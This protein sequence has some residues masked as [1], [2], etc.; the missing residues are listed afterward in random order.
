MLIL[1]IYYFDS[2]YIYMKNEII[3]NLLITQV[4]YNLDIFDI[5]NNYK[6]I[7]TNYIKKRQ[8]NIIFNISKQFNCLSSS[9][10]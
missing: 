2:S 3:N 1:I 8:L 10:G 9:T 6:I 4:F 7:T 5:G